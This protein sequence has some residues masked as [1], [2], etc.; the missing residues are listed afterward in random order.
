ML[1]GLDK[2]KSMTDSED[3]FHVVEVCKYNFRS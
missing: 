1:L 2:V 3:D